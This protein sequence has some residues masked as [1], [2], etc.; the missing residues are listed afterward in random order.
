[1]INI[2]IRKSDKCNCE[3]SLF[4]SFPYNQNT[5]DSIKQ[6]PYRYWNTN[7]REW[8]IPLNKLQYVLDLFKSSVVDIFDKDGVL[9]RHQEKPV[10]TSLNYQFKTTPFQHQMDG[11][12]YGLEHDKWLLGD[13]QGLGKTKQ[14]IDLACIKKKENGYK[15]CLIICGVNGLKWNWQNEINIHSNETGYIIGQRVKNNKIIIGSN[16]DKAYDLDNIDKINDYFLI[17]N[18]ESLRDDAILTKLIKLCKSGEISMIA[19]DEVH[20]MKNPSSQ[21]GK[22]FLKLQAPQMVAM[23]GT[24][25][26]NTPLDLYIILKWLGYETHSFYLFKNHYCE[27]GG[28]GGYQ[29]VG[30]K[31]L[32]E[33]QVK[34]DEIMLR[35]L[36]NDVL[37]LPDKLYVDEYVE[38]D[39]EQDKIYK[40]VTCELRNN[41]DKIKMSNNPLS[42]L[43]RLRQATGYPGILSS[44]VT[45]SAKLDRMEELV[46]DAIENGKKVVIFSNWTQITDIVKERLSSKYRCLVITGDTK[47]NERQ[48]AINKFQTDSNY[49]IMIGSIGALGTGV[50]LTEGSVE[51]FLDEPW[52][53][54]LKDQ[55]E[56]RCHRIG[57]KNNITIYTLLTKGTID[58]KIHSLVYKKG[59]MS[60]LLVDNISDINKDELVDYLLS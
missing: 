41:I 47:D 59:K 24:P 3:Y 45:K 30:Y 49:K 1:M 27:M 33:L 17:T 37:D 43:I 9:F 32:K 60:D 35:R 56:D 7:T 54:A 51:I 18:V 44:K 11:L 31:N 4:L 58:E 26:M 28:Y 21:Q 5:V 36:K 57:Q 25:L 12:K 55:A 10:K 20:K 52:N 19:A 15:H 50:T 34:L 2:N 38:M 6:L 40:E 48:D 29:I 8:E 22:A 23:T 13:E 42:E 16:K 46:D 53:K 39:N 14:I